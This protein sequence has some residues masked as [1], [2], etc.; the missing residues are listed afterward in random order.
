M[1]DS[2]TGDGAQSRCVLPLTINPILGFS[3]V[4]LPSLEATTHP[5]STDFEP[6]VFNYVTRVY[7]PARIQ[8]SPTLRPSGQLSLAHCRV[9][10]LGVLVDD[11]APRIQR[12][13]TVDLA[14][15]ILFGGVVALCLFGR[16]L[17]IT[18]RYNIQG[19]PI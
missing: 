18:Y 16:I 6:L 5:W 4:L 13:A 7:R 14:D 15:I 11:Q 17:K 8:R 12:D 19:G 3:K 1:I 10:G 9:C 2:T